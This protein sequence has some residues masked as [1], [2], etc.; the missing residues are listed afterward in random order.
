MERHEG[1]TSRE[2]NLKQLFPPSQEG[3]IEKKIKG[4]CLKDKARIWP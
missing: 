3:T 2:N 1:T 4:F